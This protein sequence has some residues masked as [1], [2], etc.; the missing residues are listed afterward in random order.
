[1]SSEPRNTLETMALISPVPFKKYFKALK[2]KMITCTNLM[3]KTIPTDDR[4]VCSHCSGLFKFYFNFKHAAFADG[5]NSGCTH[6]G[7]P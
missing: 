3:N 7:S 6:F 5:E 4:I 1:M 2:T